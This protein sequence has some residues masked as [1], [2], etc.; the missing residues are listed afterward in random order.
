MDAEP[1][2]SAPRSV[3][4]HVSFSVLLSLVPPSARI[5]FSL[6]LHDLHD[7]AVSPQVTNRHLYL[8]LSLDEYSSG[9]PNDSDYSG[10]RDESK[11]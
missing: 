1:K 8:Y 7:P 2:I 5:S 11:R 3:D 4:E 10:V 6:I 9:T